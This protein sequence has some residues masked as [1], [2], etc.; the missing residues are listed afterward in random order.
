MQAL[1]IVELKT[2][3]DFSSEPPTSFVSEAQFYLEILFMA[4]GCLCYV[5]IDNVL[6]ALLL[7]R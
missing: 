5:V 4:H 6:H 7:V 2:N 3:S 1:A